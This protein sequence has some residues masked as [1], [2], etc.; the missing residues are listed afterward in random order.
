MNKLIL[1][2]ISLGLLGCY[3][4]PKRDLSSVNKKMIYNNTKFQL[5]AFKYFDS[6]FDKLEKEM[7]RQLNIVIDQV[8]INGG[9]IKEIVKQLNRNT[10]QIRREYQRR[11]L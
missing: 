1:I 7:I 11:V 10:M 9:N 8:N 5:D 4:A 2:V 3:T 6:R